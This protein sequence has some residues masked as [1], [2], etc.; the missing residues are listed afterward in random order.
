MKE[1]YNQHQ[2]L[3]L[4]NGVPREQNKMSQSELDSLSKSEQEGIGYNPNN[5]RGDVGGPGM[6]PAHDG[7]GNDDEE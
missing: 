5:P 7:I 4:K 1:S 3:W 2:T 6:S